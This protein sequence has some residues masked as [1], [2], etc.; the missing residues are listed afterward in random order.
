MFDYF[1]LPAVL[2]A[3]LLSEPRVRL[4]RLFLS[5]PSLAVLATPPTG[6]FMIVIHLVLPANT[7][8]GPGFLPW[9][10]LY[11]PHPPILTL[12]LLPMVIAHTE[13]YN[14][15]IIP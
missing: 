2:K 15:S 6:K 10:M 11:L 13:Q 12:P 9:T 5:L 4:A 7:L 14:G 8:A 3:N 1:G